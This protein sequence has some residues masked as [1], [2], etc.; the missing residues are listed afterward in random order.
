MVPGFYL[1]RKFHKSFYFVVISSFSSLTTTYLLHKVAT[2]R[3]KSGKR[4]GTSIN[5]LFIFF[6]LDHNVKM[7]NISMNGLPPVQI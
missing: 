1:K 4:Q 7:E 3:K 5:N 6:S 2:V